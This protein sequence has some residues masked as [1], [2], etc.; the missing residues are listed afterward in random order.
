MTTPDEW[1]YAACPRCGSYDTEWEPCFEC[2]GEGEFDLHDDDPVN[3]APD[4]EYEGNDLLDS[5]EV[6]R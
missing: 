5:P 3:Y 2:L 6:K 4:E 1:G